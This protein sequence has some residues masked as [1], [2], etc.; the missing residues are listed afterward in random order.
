MD[1]GYV[2]HGNAFSISRIVCGVI[3]GTCPKR[4]KGLECNEGFPQGKRKYSTVESGINALQNHGLN[5]CPDNAIAGL[6]RYVPISVLA[7]NLKNLGSIIQQ[8]KFIKLKKATPKNSGKP[9]R[10][11][12]KTIS[13]EGGLSILY[14]SPEKLVKN[15]KPRGGFDISLFPSTSFW[16]RG[17]SNMIFLKN[18]IFG[19]TL[20]ISQYQTQ[21]SPASPQ[22]LRKT[23]GKSQ[24][25]SS[26]TSCAY[27]SYTSPSYMNRCRMVSLLPFQM[28]QSVHHACVLRS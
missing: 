21:V 3:F 12:K 1:R 7:R 5:R 28:V 16:C 24:F 17:D 2:E 4:P 13:K 8:A 26:H 18:G 9:L 23:Y 19:Q 11:Q 22:F 25:P 10:V 6:R 15:R 14:T 20:T 27:C